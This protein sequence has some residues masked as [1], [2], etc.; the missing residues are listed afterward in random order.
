MKPLCPSTVRRSRLPKALSERLGPRRRADVEHA[1]NR[2]DGD[3]VTEQ[4][5][6]FD[7]FGGAEFRFHSAEQLIG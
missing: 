4:A 7:E 5:D 1:D 2:A 3:V 6:A